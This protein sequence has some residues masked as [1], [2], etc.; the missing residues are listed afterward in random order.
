MSSQQYDIVIVGAGPAGLG[1]AR[2][3]ARLGFRT[4]V[5][6]RLSASGDLSHPCGAMIAPVPGFVSA[7]RAD[8]GIR[9]AELDLSLPS[10][11]IVGYPTV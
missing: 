7:Q 3:A 8:R 5:L 9:F 1:A 6:D 4:L 10:S 11:L 2:T